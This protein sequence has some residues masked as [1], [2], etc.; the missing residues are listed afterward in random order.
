MIRF[1]NT[2][3]NDRIRRQF[4]KDTKI[5]KSYIKI[6]L[7]F[8][9]ENH[10]DYRY[11]TINEQRINTLPVNDNIDSRLTHIELIKPVMD[12]RPNTLPNIEYIQEDFKRSPAQSFVPNLAPTVIEIKIL[13][14]ALERG[15]QHLLMPF[16]LITSINI[17]HGT[18]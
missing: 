17:F 12:I 7:D 3:N 14:N 10:P 8:L 16:F 18:Q 9:K 5:R 13:R 1:P 11:I 15:R 2:E 4:M 6:W